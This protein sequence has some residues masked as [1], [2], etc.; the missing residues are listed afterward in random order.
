[1]CEISKGKD[2]EESRKVRLSYVPGI[3]YNWPSF[4]S[5]SKKLERVEKFARARFNYL[6]NDL[7]IF[8]IKLNSKNT[9]NKFDI[10]VLNPYGEEEILLCPY[11]HFT[12]TNVEPKPFKIVQGNVEKEINYMLIDIEELDEASLAVQLLWF[13]PNI[14]T[15]ENKEYQIPFTEFFKLSPCYFVH[16]IDEAKNI[17]ETE[18]NV[19]F[20][21]K[22]LKCWKI[23]YTGIQGI[24]F[25]KY[26]FFASKKSN[27]RSGS[28]KIDTRI[29]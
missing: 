15:K 14:N 1:M 5:T 26:V 28:T 13:D 7:V 2:S 16:S 18:K 4:T 3:F 11:F 22:L 29:T 12:I 25:I 23:K 19:K 6:L 24:I 21:N 27:M 10:D 8:R 17:I 9:K 20:G